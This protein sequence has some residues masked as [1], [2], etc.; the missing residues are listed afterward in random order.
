MPRAASGGSTDDLL[1]PSLFLKQQEWE[2]KSRWRS[3]FER[4]IP[5]A[6]VLRF[7]QIENAIDS[8]IA[9]E[10][11]GVTPLGLPAKQAGPASAAA[12][13]RSGTARRGRRVR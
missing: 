10:I 5:P 13:R 12:P 2:L 11:S 3:K 1:E 7:H 9:S 4:A 8:A 6:M